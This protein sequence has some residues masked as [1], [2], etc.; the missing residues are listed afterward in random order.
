MSDQKHKKGAANTLTTTMTRPPTYDERMD[1]V[2]SIG[3]ILSGPAH[4]G[5]G[6]K[7]F[8]PSN[9]GGIGANGAILSTTVDDN[10]AS[11]RLNGISS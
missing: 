9:D 3:S 11:S 4:L 2:G 6:S 1:E 5:P 10:Q 7:N 8:K